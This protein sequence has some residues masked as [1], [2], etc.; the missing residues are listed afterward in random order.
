MQVLWLIYLPTEWKREKVISYRKSGDFVCAFPGFLFKFHVYFEVLIKYCNLHLRSWI[1]MQRRQRRILLEIKHA[2]EYGMA[3]KLTW[4]CV[5]NSDLFFWLVFFL[6]SFFK[7]IPIKI[8]ETGTCSL[9]KMDVSSCT[10]HSL[11]LESEWIPSLILES[12]WTPSLTWSQS[13][14]HPW[15]GVRVDPIPD[16]GVRVGLIPDLESEWVS[17]LN[18]ESEWVSSLN[19]ESEWVPCEC[20][21]TGILFVYIILAH[22]KECWFIIWKLC[23]DILRRITPLDLGKCPCRSCDTM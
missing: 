15:P 5:C 8:K 11:T 3:R 19:L 4:P 6:F 10:P 18:L 1:E 16:P 12:E 9:I 14:S 13:G 23:Y 7:N 22:V 17:S 20:C 21:S 2:S